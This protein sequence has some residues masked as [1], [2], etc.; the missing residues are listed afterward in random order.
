MQKTLPSLIICLLATSIT[1]FA[2]NVWHKKLPTSS[3]N[4]AFC[5]L[6][7]DGEQYFVSSSYSFTQIDKFG[8]ITG[9][10]QKGTTLSPFW[11][12]VI[13]KYDT[14]TGHP[15]FW[16]IHR[17]S[18]PFQNYTFQEY[19][20]GLGY[21]NE[22]I[23]PDSLTSFSTWN[24]PQIININDSTVVVFGRKY[25]RQI[26]QSAAGEFLEEWVRPL[27]LPVTAALLHNNLFIL[28]DEFGTVTALDAGG[29][30]VW[31]H[32]H[33]IALR[34]LKPVPG[35]IAGCGHTFDDK[36][37]VILMD[38]DGTEVWSTITTDTDYY[39]ATSTS[40]GGFVAT[41]IS[42]ALNICLTKLNA[43]GEP[44]WEQEYAKGAGFGVLEES[45]GGFVVGGRTSPS[46]MRVF[47]TD[48][49]GLTAPVK[50]AFVDYRH[51][52]T[53]SVQAKLGPT[54]TLFFDKS[55][56]TFISVPDSAA[57]IFSFAPWIGGLD[58]ASNMYLAADDYSPGGDSDYR[59]GFS[60]SNIND[61][62]RVWLI[63]QNE[64]D[65]LRF[66]FSTDQTLNSPVPFDLMTWPARGNPNLRY[67]PDFTLIATD[68]ML[69]PAPFVDA[70]SDG[71]Y[72][73]YDGDYP[74]IKGDRMVWWMLTDSVEHE[75]TNGEIVGVDLLISV[76]VF[77][78]PQNGSVDG[79]IFVDFE[80]INRS[81]TNYLN[82]Y[83]GFFT[84]FDLGCYIDDYIGTMPDVN[85][86]YV[87][88]QD[89]FDNIPCDQ[90]VP[91]FGND[92]PIQA[93]TFL[94]Q[95]LDRSIYFNN[96]SVGNPLPGTQDPDLPI[97]F[98]NYLQGIWK[99]GVA[100]TVGG[101]GYNPGSTNYVNHVFPDNPADLN[102]WSMCAENLP[103]GDRR[104]INSHGPFTFV[105]GDTF[106][107][108]L[109]FTLHPDIPHPCTDVVGL[110][111]PT[112]AQIKQ[113][114]DD[115][116]LVANTNLPEVVNLPPGQSVLL[117]AAV[118]GATY[119]WSTGATATGIT[120]TQPGEYTVTVTPATGCPIVENVLVQLGT[121]AKQPTSAPAWKI[122]PNPAGD[123][124]LVD[125]PECGHEN[126]EIVLR[127]AQG[128]AM[129]NWQGQ[130]RQTRLD[131][132]HFSPGFYWL[133]LW[134][135]EQFLGSKKLVL[136][137]W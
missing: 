132:R 87:Y 126:L 94:N 54:P 97:Q 43:A 32:N 93:V 116:S 14:A 11:S 112:I 7:T 23:F 134:Q 31:S 68:P 108:Q 38:F 5:Q 71:I 104:M 29:N 66:D 90:S 46:G 58:G 1:S 20:P 98:Y 2:Q 6:A 28:A 118:P 3:F 77:D 79:S 10:F 37:G 35:G 131:L 100:P 64:I 51:V 85:T 135:G 109:A 59:S 133:E 110:V 75:R 17:G 57:T 84:D 96:A 56:A 62:Q 70:N 99:D 52:Q 128:A 47:K 121:S 74:R 113:W 42:S 120:V 48:A 53:S 86:F 125:C 129:L 103:F 34:T 106:H 36:A 30:Q 45:D 136:A 122:Q 105:S 13:K 82:T 15:Y 83:M 44:V 137:G 111:K 27:N 124:V 21:V 69:L 123:F 115:G 12:S 81:S 88:N 40:D 49:E 50:D 80:V 9:F 22:K 8:T 65:R 119:Q 26:K 24:R 4:A 114:N 101:S 63:S 76:Y 78:C 127:N 39:D 130:N 67:N 41:G 107:I 73:V 117:D 102:G 92:I 89:A 91:G 33:G 18:S 95:S 16:V 25:Y 55:D 60:Q 61:Y 19:R 72:N